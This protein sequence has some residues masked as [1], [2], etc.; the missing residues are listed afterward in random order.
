[1]SNNDNKTFLGEINHKSLFSV[2][3]ATAA[4]AAAGHHLLT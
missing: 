3:A 1:M 2:L 4:A